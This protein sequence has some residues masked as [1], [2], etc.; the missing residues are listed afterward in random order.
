MNNFPE[1]LSQA[2]AV[3]FDMDGTLIDSTEADYL[4]WKRLF[5]RHHVDLSFEKYFTML[6]IRSADLVRKE[7]QLKDAALEEALALK[8][9]YFNEL[10][11]D[12]GI[13]PIAFAPEFVQQLHAQPIQLAL[14]T[15][16]RR[17]KMQ[18]MMTMTHLL[19]Y[20]KAIVTGEEVTKGK[21]AP[22]IFLLAAEK[23]G[24]A[25]GDCIVFEDAFHG[26]KAAKNAGMTCVAI[27]TTHPAHLLQE[28]DLVIESYQ[29][30]MEAPKIL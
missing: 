2:K 4:A 24:V 23:L 21:P 11:N 5:A 30:F 15:S 9:H 6:G 17:E 1:R 27:S 10:V 19:P 29:V 16:S 26:V 12:N 14:A 18:R 28:A 25:P 13:R 20:F 22:D 7:L 3:I 8:L